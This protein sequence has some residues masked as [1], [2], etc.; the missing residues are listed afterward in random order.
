LQSFNSRSSEY[1]V[2]KKSLDRVGRESRVA[3]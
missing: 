2:N 3:L 1:K